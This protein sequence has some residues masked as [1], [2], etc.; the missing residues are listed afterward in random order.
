[1]FAYIQMSRISISH[2]RK[3]IFIIFTTIIIFTIS[4]KNHTIP[5]TFYCIEGLSSHEN[6]ILGSNTRA[7]GSATL[8]KQT[9]TIL[10][11]LKILIPA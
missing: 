5:W 4:Y 8:V 6:L 9:N 2:Q 11:D 1:M 7:F 10:K 3:A